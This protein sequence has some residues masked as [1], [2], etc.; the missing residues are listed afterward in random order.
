MKEEG[1]GEEMWGYGCSMGVLYIQEKETDLS[2]SNSSHPD[3][4]ANTDTGPATRAA[5]MRRVADAT[6]TIVYLFIKLKYLLFYY[7]RRWAVINTDN[8]RRLKGRGVGGRDQLREPG[9]AGVLLIYPTL[10]LTHI[11]TLLDSPRLSNQR[12]IV[13]DTT[14]AVRTARI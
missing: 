3:P 5:A 11:L 1:E 14:G 7:W 13:D 10:T 8:N 12:G 4:D 9:M 6:L 2:S